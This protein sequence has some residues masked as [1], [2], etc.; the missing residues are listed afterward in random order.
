MN[1]EQEQW[2]GGSGC[3]VKTKQ[4]SS[5]WSNFQLEHQY[6][7]IQCKHMNKFTRRRTLTQIFFFFVEKSNPNKQT[8]SWLVWEYK[9]V[10]CYS[11]SKCDL[12]TENASDRP[13]TPNTL[14]PAMIS[15][16]FAQCTEVCCHWCTHI[17]QP[18]MFWQHC[19]K[20]G[21]S[22]NLQNQNE[23]NYSFSLCLPLVFL[24]Y[25][26]TV[27]SFLHNINVFCFLKKH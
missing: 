2:I 9:S 8:Y 26:A 25:W 5:H 12:R 16:H 18:I 3:L 19:G 6:C 15:P 1:W 27:L 10:K 22:M 21:S 11:C 13:L 7:I 23:T 17:L 14:L 4:Y 24:M 20:T